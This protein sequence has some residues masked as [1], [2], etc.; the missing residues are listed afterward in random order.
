MSVLN[1]CK[2][3]LDLSDFHYHAL[4]EQLSALSWQDIA[5]ANWSEEYPYKP[6]VQFQIAH[7]NQH[8]ILHYA[9]EEDFIKGRYVRP[10]E[11][12][13][14]DSCVEFF[15][16]FDGK[17]TYYNIEFNVLG[18]GLIGYGPADKSLR[19]RL[20]AEDILQVQTLSSVIN[21]AGRKQWNIIMLIPIHLFKAQISEKLTG[22]KAAANFYKCG[23]ELPNPHFLSWKAID[24]PTPNFHL[25]AF[26]GELIFE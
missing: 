16:S 3:D 25:P 9:V 20:A 26:F 4:Q 24:H 12:V 5:Q 1:V 8:I 11:A 7:D 18:T 10:N 21:G 23:D 19:N 6:K 15:L 2:V 14:E 13:W 17:A 22:L